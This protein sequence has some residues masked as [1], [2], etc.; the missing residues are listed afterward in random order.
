VKKII[1]GLAFLAV[2]FFPI[3]VQAQQPIRVK[4]GSAAALTDSKGQVWQPD[5]GYNIGSVYTDSASISGTADPALYLTGRNNGNTNPLI[6]T[7]PV[8]NGNYH[9]NL[10]FAET[11]GKMFH[12]GARVTNIRIQGAVTFPNLD[13]FA[14]V[15]ADAALVEGT[16]VIVSNNALTIEFDNVVAST[17]INAIEI[18]PVSNTAPTLSLNFVYPDGTTVSGALLYTITSNLLSFRG[19]TPL[20]NG[21]AQSNLITSPASLGLNLD[22]QVNLSLKD[23]AGNLLWQ[24]TLG[25]NPSQIN[26]GAVQSSVLTVVV[27][28]P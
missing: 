22:F 21:M 16:D 20:V 5:T 13:V 27:Q 1:C 26:L 10:Y 8:S 7:F 12:V 19:T 6:Y 28:K 9:V 15:G 3:G 25:M 23:T 11:A 17:H 24:F 18:F 4:C 2:F 14:S